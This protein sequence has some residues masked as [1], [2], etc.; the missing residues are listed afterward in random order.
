MQKNCLSILNFYVI[1]MLF[2]CYF[3]MLDLWSTFVCQC[4]A[5]V[6]A[7]IDFGEEENVEEGLYPEG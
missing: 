6:E 5:H 7:I 4:V 1:L 2:L 3:D